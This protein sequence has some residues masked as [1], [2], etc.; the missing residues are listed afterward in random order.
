MPKPLLGII[1]GAIIG[2]L[3]GMTAILTPEADKVL[4]IA[5]WSS[6]KGLIV[7]LIIGFYARKVDS[8]PKGVVF[9]LGVA[10]FFAF[11]TAL[12]Q[13]LGAGQHYWLEIMLPGTITGGIVGYA[14]QRF[15][16]QPRL[17]ESNA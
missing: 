10:L 8:V 2:F 13:Y 1:L 14:V 5:T 15:G 7:G 17:A 12:G 6:G 9:G 3:D 11:L 4:E 16:R